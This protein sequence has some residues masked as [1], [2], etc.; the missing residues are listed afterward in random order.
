MLVILVFGKLDVMHAIMP[1]FVSRLRKQALRLMMWG[2]ADC[3]F[4]ALRVNYWLIPT[5]V[6][7]S[8]STVIFPHDENIV[9]IIWNSLFNTVHIDTQDQ[10]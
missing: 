8:S 9:L 4:K 1:R 6:V 10:T 5:Y 7:H 2:I 3:S